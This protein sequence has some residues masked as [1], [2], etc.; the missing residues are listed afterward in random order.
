MNTN[1]QNVTLLKELKSQST[2][3]LLILSI[4]TLSIY[5]AYYVKRQ[6]EIINKHIEKDRQ[7]TKGFVIAFYLVSCM[8]AFLLV[9]SF[10]ADGEDLRQIELVSNI[11]DYIWIIMDIAWA[12]IARS[13]MHKLFQNYNENNFNFSILWSIIF[14]VYYF[15]FKINKLNKRMAEP[16]A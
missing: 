11:F 16:C 15:N 2:W 4:I 9:P 7:I 3:R 6:S 1:N 8:A 13:K 10:L 12:L 5:D 14:G